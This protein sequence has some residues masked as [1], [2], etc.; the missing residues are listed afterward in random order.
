VH[1]DPENIEP[2]LMDRDAAM[3]AAR[4]VKAALMHLHAARDVLDATVADLYDAFSPLAELF[5]R[6]DDAMQDADLWAINNA[7]RNGCGRETYKTT[8]RWCHREGGE[9]P[10]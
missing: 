3:L 1:I 9:F 8:D 10:R 5:R 7:A 4:H 6:A 2:V